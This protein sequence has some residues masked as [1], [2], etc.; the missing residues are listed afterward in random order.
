MNNFCLRDLSRNVLN[1]TV[2]DEWE[3]MRLQG[4]YA[5]LL[6]IN[7]LKEF[8]EMRLFF[9]MLSRKKKNLSKFLFFSFL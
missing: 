5:S 9:F 1:G 7:H 8:P 6:L 3:N 4:L 2:P